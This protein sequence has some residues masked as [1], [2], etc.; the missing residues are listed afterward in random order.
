MKTLISAILIS[1]LSFAV[2]AQEQPKEQPNEIQK[3]QSRLD[4][5]ENKTVNVGI[6]LG[7]RRLTCSSSKNYYEPSISPFD[8]TLKFQ[9][10]D[11]SSMVLSTDLVINPFIRTTWK[12]SLTQKIAGGI[13]NSFVK[14]GSKFLLGALERFTIV[15]SIDLIEFQ[16]ASSEFKFNKQF[17]GGIGLGIKLHPNCWIGWTHDIIQTNQLRDFVKNQEN[18]KVIVD[19]KIVTQLDQSDNKLFY[20]KNI[21]SNTFKIIVK[22]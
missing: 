1:G 20:K 16:S 8:S 2:Y 14:Y 22:L 5:I 6:S 17:N 15:I 12:E 13:T 9:K 19:N 4:K 10:L 7:Y 3:L 21:S 11:P 18:K